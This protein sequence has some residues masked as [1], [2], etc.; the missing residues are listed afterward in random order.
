[1]SKAALDLVKQ[2][3]EWLRSWYPTFYLVLGWMVVAFSAHKILKPM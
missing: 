2:D 1:M 3:G